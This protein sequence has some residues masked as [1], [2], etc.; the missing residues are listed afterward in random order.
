M[1]QNWLNKDGL[2][3]QYGADK[4]IAET[5]GEF[6]SYGDNRVIEGFLDLTTLTTT[7]LITS[8]TT[9]FPAALSGQMF[10]EQVVL[11]VEVAATTSSSSTLSIG[12]I[13]TDQAT[14]PANYGTAFVNAL[15]QTALTPLATKV[16]LIGG[17]TGAGGLIGSGP[18]SATGPYYITAATGTGTFTAGKIRYRIYYRGQ[19]PITQ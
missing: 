12:L 5:A 7:A 10:I 11:D 19:P 8:Y 2:F 13:Q 6:L 1:A 4:A 17:S 14:V 3:L 16:T 9:L 18:A 15:A